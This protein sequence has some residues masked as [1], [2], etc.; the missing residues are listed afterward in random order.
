MEEQAEQNRRKAAEEMA[1]Q[2]RR[3]VVED[4]AEKDKLA[5]ALERAP[6]RHRISGRR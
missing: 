2:K 6:W 3:K 5:E 1:A 4:K